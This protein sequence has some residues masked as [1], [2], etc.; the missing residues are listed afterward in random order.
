MTWMMLLLAGRFFEDRRLVDVNSSPSALIV[1]APPWIIV[2]GDRPS[3]ADEG[4]HAL[5]D[6]V[7][8]QRRRVDRLERPEQR[9]T[10]HRWARTPVY[11]PVRSSS[12]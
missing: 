6:V 11:M 3:N 4:M 9:R 5:G 7:G 8:E 2:S 10:P 1:T 12:V